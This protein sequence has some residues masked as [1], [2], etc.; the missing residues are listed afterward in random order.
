MSTANRIG[1]GLAVFIIGLGCICA[2]L[3][4]GDQY[5]NSGENFISWF[6]GQ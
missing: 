6:V 1:L 4:F 5:V 3:Y 2:L